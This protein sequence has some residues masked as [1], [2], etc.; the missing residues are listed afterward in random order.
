M[1]RI[2]HRFN[3]VAVAGVAV[4]AAVAASPLAAD[5][6]PIPADGVCVSVTPTV[7]ATCPSASQAPVS[8][9]AGTTSSQSSPQTARPSSVSATP[10]LARALLAEVNRTRRQQGLRTLSYS[11]SLTQAATAHVQLLATKGQFTHDWP[12]TGAHFSSWIRGFYAARGF[13]RWSAG[14][15]LLWSSPGFSPGDAVNEWL[16]SPAHR[17]V[18]LTPSWRE[19]GVG[20]VTVS[21]APGMYGGR[22]VQIAAAEFGTRKH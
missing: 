13:R 12:T 21:G 4:I 3:W 16:A 15:N 10:Q 11:S 20:V 8:Q 7:S 14:E 1:S 5:V 9:A 6:G 19:L 22:D 18:M 2:A 17:L